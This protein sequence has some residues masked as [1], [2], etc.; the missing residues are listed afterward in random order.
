M[1]MTPD[2]SRYRPTWSGN[3][4]FQAFV[5]EP[6]DRGCWTPSLHGERRLVALRSPSAYSRFLAL[7]ARTK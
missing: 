5:L 3:P 7:S 2:P 1:A 6:M 4:S